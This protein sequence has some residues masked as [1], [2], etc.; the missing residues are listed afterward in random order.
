VLDQF[1]KQ[2]GVMTKSEAL[3]K[4]NELGVDLVEI[5]PKALPPVAK[6]INFAKFKYQI[7]QKAQEDK[8]KTKISEIKELRMTPVIAQGD[9]DGRMKKARQFLEDGDK[10]R[11]NVKFAG[12][13]ITKKE[14]GEKVL[15]RAVD[16][17][18]DISMVEIA[19]K[20]IGKFMM[21]QLSPVKKKKPSD[22]QK[23]GTAEKMPAAPK[24]PT[25]AK[26][27]VKKE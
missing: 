24:A 13:M 17:L 18:S 5:A 20:L 16:Q 10:V 27:E 22:I 6:L 12:R 23:Q 26:Q 11:L 21:M 1:N 2:L 7:A 9:F 25:Q 4:A 15:K 3:K 14:Y 8:R 19:P